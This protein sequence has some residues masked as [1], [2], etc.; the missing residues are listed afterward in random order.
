MKVSI[1]DFRRQLAEMTY[2]QLLCAQAKLCAELTVGEKMAHMTA[3]EIQKRDD[4]KRMIAYREYIT[5]ENIIN[6][7]RSLEIQPPEGSD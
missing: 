2:E 3:D 4:V 5:P 7:A 1:D 6:R